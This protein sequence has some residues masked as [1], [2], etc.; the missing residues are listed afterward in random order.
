[1]SFITVTGHSHTD[2]SENSSV[3]DD[4]LE[5]KQTARHSINR[6]PYAGET[7]SHVPLR[8]SSTRNE[9]SHYRYP[10][11]QQKDTRKSQSL[12]QTTSRTRFTE[13]K[14][15]DLHALRDDLERDSSSATLESTKNSASYTPSSSSEAAPISTAPSSLSSTLDASTGGACF[16]AES[17]KPRKAAAEEINAQPLTGV[18]SPETSIDVS[19]DIADEPRKESNVL[20][21]VAQLDQSTCT[22]VTALALSV[23]P[24]KKSRWTW[25]RSKLIALH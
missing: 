8:Q 17:E 21:H 1:M 20:S 4:G 7:K 19:G 22:Q 10:S 16:P 12:P 13:P 5:M 25:R 11:R 9:D 15:M 18:L 6:M 3:S 14:P 2:A 23:K 24:S